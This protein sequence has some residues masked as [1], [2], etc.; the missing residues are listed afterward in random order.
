MGKSSFGNLLVYCMK[1]SVWFNSKPFI[2]SSS[3]SSSFSLSSLSFFFLFVFFFQLLLPIISSLYSHV[4][5]VVAAGRGQSLQRPTPVVGQP[6]LD[7]DDIFRSSVRLDVSG[8]QVREISN[9]VIKKSP[10]VRSKT[11]RQ[12]DSSQAGEA[13]GSSDSSSSPDSYRR[14]HGAIKVLVYSVF[15]EY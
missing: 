5:C 6:T 4:T 3:T 11:F 12:T 9:R 2:S 10:D 7:A 8:N 13:S 1:A 14:G 15:L